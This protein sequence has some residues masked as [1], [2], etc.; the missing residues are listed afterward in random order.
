ME[1]CHDNL[2]C[3]GC[4]A[5]N[6]IFG[7]QD[8]PKGLSSGTRLSEYTPPRSVLETHP[9]S[10]PVQPFQASYRLTGG[11]TLPWKITVSGVYQSIPPQ[12]IGTA[13]CSIVETG[14]CWTYS[15]NTGAYTPNFG[16]NYTVTNATPNTL[17]RP[18]RHPAA[19]SPFRC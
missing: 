18:L 11:Y 3:L 2:R 9:E 10:L 7:A 12:Q 19:A 1:S 5:Q 4:L 8:L 14:A 15:P 16:A 13:A 17:G 6:Q